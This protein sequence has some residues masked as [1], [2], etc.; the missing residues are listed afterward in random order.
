[1]S[2]LE[3]RL[4][5]KR[6]SPL[7]IADALIDNEISIGADRCREIAARERIRQIGLALL[8]FVDSDITIEKYRAERCEHDE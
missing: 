2:E 6:N 8:N 3:I 4:R 1:M 5:V 7:S